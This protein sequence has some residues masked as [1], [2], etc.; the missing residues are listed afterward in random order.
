MFFYLSKAGWLLAQPSMLVLVLV[1]T[2]VGLMGTRHMKLGR[3]LALTGAL[4]LAV[5]GLSPL[6]N[7]LILPLEQ[8]FTRTE[9]SAADDIA[10]IIV[11]GGGEDSYVTAGR[12]AVA[13][14]DAAER[15]TESV[16]LARRFPKARVVFTGGSTE[17]VVAA[18]YGADAARQFFREQGIE[19]GR[20]TLE[21]RARNTY[22]NAILTKALVNPNAGER[23]LLV[24]SAF[25]MP[26]SMGCFRQAGFD[27]EPWPVDYH[28]AGPQDATRFFDRPSEGLRRIDNVAREWAGLLAYRL[29]GKTDALFPRPLEK[30]APVTARR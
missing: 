18:T 20:V 27:V 3:R 10:G 25:H 6:G 2:G 19:D 13:L 8:R 1:L 4:G 29:T 23:W 21:N 9:L 14:N 5:V 7:L 22:E 16:A 26:R 30:L 17:I 15:L 11:M 24:T 28:T 12:G